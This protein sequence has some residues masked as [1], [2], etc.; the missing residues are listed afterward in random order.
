MLTIRSDQRRLL[1]SSL[2]AEYV[3][4]LLD[5]V[6]ITLP[7][8]YRDTHTTVLRNRIGWALARAADWGFE[9]R[10]DL[11]GFV[12]LV[13]GVGPGLDV[14][15]V[16]QEVLASRTLAIEQKLETVVGRMSDDD[17]L[18]VHAS[19]APTGWPEVTGNV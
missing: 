19:P 5:H 1:Q 16:A 4:E 10:V 7:S 15:P 12:T 18:A 11:K 2:Y 9:R 6:Q 8:V 13:L 3:D 14:H 17:W